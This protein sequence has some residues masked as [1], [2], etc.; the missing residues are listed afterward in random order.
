M[1]SVIIHPMSPPH[2][3]LKCSTV[4]LTVSVG[5]DFRATG[6][7]RQPVNPARLPKSHF[8]QPFLS[9]T[10]YTMYPSPVYISIIP[11]V[12]ILIT[13]GVLFVLSL[14][15][16]VQRHFPSASVALPPDLA[17]D[18]PNPLRCVQSNSSDS[19]SRPRQSSVTHPTD[20]PLSVARPDH[21]LDAGSALFSNASWVDKDLPTLP[22]SR[23]PANAFRPPLPTPTPGTSGDLPHSTI[24]GQPTLPIRVLDAEGRVLPPPLPRSP[25]TR[26]VQGYHGR[27]G[28]PNGSIS[29]TQPSVFELPSVNSGLEEEPRSGAG[30]ARQLS[31]PG[32]ASI[33]TA[34]SRGPTSTGPN[35]SA[36]PFHHIADRIE[37]DQPDVPSSLPNLRL[38]QVRP[39]L[40]SSIPSLLPPPS[41]P[42]H[43]QP[44]SALRDA[45]LAETSIA[46]RSAVLAPHAPPESGPNAEPNGTVLEGFERWR[47]MN[48]RGW[49][50]AEALQYNP[51]LIH[52]STPVPTSGSSRAR[53]LSSLNTLPVAPALPPRPTGPPECIG[54]LIQRMSSRSAQ[55]GEDVAQA[56]VSTSRPLRVPSGPRPPPESRLRSLSQ[57]PSLP[58]AHV[59][60]TSGQLVPAPSNPAGVVERPALTPARAPAPSPTVPISASVTITSTAPIPLP[61][62]QVASMTMDEARAVARRA[63][64]AIFDFVQSTEG[65][66]TCPICMEVM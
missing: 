33:H 1:Y 22:A 7:S 51:P 24:N 37:V 19:T 49:S 35:S 31:L 11:V 17:L 41:T 18:M 4:G 47:N 23:E 6:H 54:S 20:A 12:C 16:S 25:A 60:P 26:R 30:A 58:P 50:N 10:L 14:L 45:P 32:M 46:H 3:R 28:L 64:T 42:G 61:I 27:F 57:A 38:P 52:Q 48:D 36:P 43:P 62:P 63:A 56:S 53:G 5:F 55:N 21:S 15:F 34:V 8:V 59:A 65:D 9:L 66:L 2:F 13:L 40:P 44:I 29:H 39:R